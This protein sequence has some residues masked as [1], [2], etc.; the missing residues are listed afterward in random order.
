VGGPK[1]VTIGALGQANSTF[2]G[3]LF[4]N[5]GF[6][7]IVTAAAL[8]AAPAFAADMPIKAPPPV[9]PP[10]WTWTGFYLGLNA[11]WGW[12][13]KVDNLLITTTPL[14]GGY[15]ATAAGTNPTGPFAG[16]DVGYNWQVANF[17]VFGFEADFEG[18]NIQNGFQNRVIDVFGDQ[19]SAEQALNAFSTI[20][21]RLG[22]AYNNFLV[23]GTGGLA[24]GDVHN[25]VVDVLSVPPTGTVNMSQDAWQS[26][27]AVGGGVEYMFAPHASLKVEYQYIKLGSFTG[28]ALESPPSGFVFSTNSINNNFQT[29]R[30]GLNVHL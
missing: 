25:R 8:I 4:M 21:G 2:S 22:L 18:S 15:P 3:E 6:C 24:Y 11:G 16:V 27:Y 10:A 26:G 14:L 7:V 28:S 17:L 19:L 5:R 1:V 30:V 29:V 20:R 12:D 9:P 13:A 23:Y